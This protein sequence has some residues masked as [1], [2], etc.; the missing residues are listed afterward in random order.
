MDDNNE[1]KKRTAIYNIYWRRHSCIC[2]HIMTSVSSVSVTPTTPSKDVLLL[3]KDIFTIYLEPLLKIHH[4]TT[5]ATAPDA[6]VITYEDLTSSFQLAVASL[7]KTN[8]NVDV[9]GK[10]FVVRIPLCFLTY[11]E[12]MNIYNIYTVVI[13]FTSP[14]VVIFERCVYLIHPRCLSLSLSLSCS[15]KCICV[16]FHSVKN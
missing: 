5:S 4:Q 6:N 14:W 2:I 1:M 16:F 11:C 10:N 8:T 15:Y 12:N 13:F 3:Q 9:N 7:G